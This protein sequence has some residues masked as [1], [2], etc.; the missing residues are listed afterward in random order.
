MKLVIHFVLLISLWATLIPALNALD[1][2]PPEIRLWFLVINVVVSTR[3]LMDVH[4]AH[5]TRGERG[6][7]GPRG[8][9]GESYV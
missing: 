1:T 7:R 5:M 6:E 2:A 3:I 4:T 8:Y 9:D